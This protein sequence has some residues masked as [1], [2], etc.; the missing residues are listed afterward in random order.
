MVTRRQAREI[1]VQSLYRIEMNEVSAEEAVHAVLEQ[2][3]SEHEQEQRMEMDD[4]TLNFILTLVKGVR[5]RVERIDSIIGRNLRGWK[6]DRLSRV[7]RQI[8]RIA[9]F[10][11]MFG[12]E[13]PPVVA[14]NEAVE[15]AKSFGDEQSGKFVN[16]VL[17]KILQKKNKVEK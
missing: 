11:M 10:E 1:A 9:V 13:I 4:R 8:L 7:D 16:G 14:V 3:R 17:G 12:D 6:L 15:L 2:I 5:E